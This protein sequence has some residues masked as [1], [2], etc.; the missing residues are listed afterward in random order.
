VAKSIKTRFFYVPQFQLG[1]IRSRDE[2]RPIAREGKYLMDKILG[3]YNA[4]AEYGVGRLDV[5]YT[6]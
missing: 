6:R 5:A 2:F 3:K 4:R 1:N